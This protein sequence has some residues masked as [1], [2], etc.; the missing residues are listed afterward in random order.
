VAWRAALA[1]GFERQRNLLRLHLPAVRSRSDGFAR[2]AASS[3][4][5]SATQKETPAAPDTAACSV[6]YAGMFG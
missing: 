3:A 2:T 6:P 1:E 5:Q 4:D